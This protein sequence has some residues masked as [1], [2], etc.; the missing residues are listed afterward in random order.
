MLGRSDGV[1]KPAGV[2][3]GSAEIY[4]ILTRFFAATVADAV[5]VGRRRPVNGVDDAADETVCLF[6]V[7]Q[8]G[9]AFVRGETDAAIRAVIREQLSPRHVPA[10]VEECGPEGTPKTANGKKIEV[11]VKQILSDMPVRTNAS[12]AN[13]GALDWFRTWAAQHP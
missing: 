2:R 11:A 12:V 13:P 5:C 8:P 10:V 6:V 4:N 7:M 1:L 9:A 3:F